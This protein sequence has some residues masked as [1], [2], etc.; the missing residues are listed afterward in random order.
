MATPKSN[1]SS[2][3]SLKQSELK[4]YPT[5]GAQL[6]P[7]RTLTIE[8][9]TRQ[10]ICVCFVELTLN[11]NRCDHIW[12]VHIYL[13]HGIPPESYVCPL[14]GGVADAEFRRMRGLCDD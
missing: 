14:C 2:K 6:A 8:L 10:D 13:P 5:R 11:C 9:A 4:M 1:Y 7:L 3:K 12:K